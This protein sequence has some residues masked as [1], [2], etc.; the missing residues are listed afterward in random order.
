MVETPRLDGCLF[1]SPFS[2]QQ[3][4]IAFAIV[5]GFP[6]GFDGKIVLLGDL[7]RTERIGTQCLAIQDFRANTST[8]CQL[9][10]AGAALWLQ[11]LVADW[12]R[13]G[14]ILQNRPF[15]LW[16]MGSYQ[17][18]P[19]ACHAGNV[20]LLTSGRLKVAAGACPNLPA[21]AELYRTSDDATDKRAETPVDDHNHALA[22]L[23]YLVMKLDAGRNVRTRSVETLED[24]ARKREE[25]ERQ[26]R[27]EWMSVRNEAWWRTR[28]G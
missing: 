10:I 23:R 15:H 16:S 5:D 12:L 14:L 13:H 6:N 28:G 3:F 9:L 20:I 4:P 21:E 7:L 27:R 25:Y 26:K 24:K 22:A 1:T 11:M 17:T 18:L 2:V 8:Y 19:V